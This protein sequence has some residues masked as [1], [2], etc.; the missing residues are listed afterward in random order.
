M[1]L[2]Q[3]IAF[4]LHLVLVTYFLSV[5]LVEQE[6]S[7]CVVI[8]AEQFAEMCQLCVYCTVFMFIYNPPYPRMAVFFCCPLNPYIFCFVLSVF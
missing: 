1:F 8:E 4:S 6:V 5:H 7:E 2:I 3:N